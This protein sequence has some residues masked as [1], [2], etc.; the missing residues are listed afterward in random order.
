[1]EEGGEEEYG[2]RMDDGHSSSLHHA[3]RPVSW[4]PATS[5]GQK[6]SV[7]NLRGSNLLGVKPFERKKLPLRRRRRQWRLG[8]RLITRGPNN[9]ISLLPSY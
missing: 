3:A 4:V 9:K 7:K 6:N 5:H 2:E 1:M 8:M